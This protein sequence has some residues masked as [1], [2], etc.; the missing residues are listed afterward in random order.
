[1]RLKPITCV[2]WAFAFSLAC[3]AA[4]GAQPTQP[5]DGPYFPTAVGQTETVGSRA[6]PEIRGFGLGAVNGCI[7]AVC[8]KRAP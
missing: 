4:A 5:K 2:E 1:M 6:E 3:H 8:P 7:E